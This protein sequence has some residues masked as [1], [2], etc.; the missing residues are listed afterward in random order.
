MLTW[1]VFFYR[2]PLPPPPLLPPPLLP[3]L[4]T[5]WPCPKFR[6][7]CFEIW[8]GP[9]FTRLFFEISAVRR[10]KERGQ[11]CK[12]HT[13]AERRYVGG[14]SIWIHGSATRNETRKFLESMPLSFLRAGPPKSRKKA[15]ESW[16]HP[17]LET[18]FAKLTPG[19]T[20]SVPQS[21]PTAH[22]TAERT[23]AVYPPLKRPQPWQF[24]QKW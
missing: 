3:V 7:I 11:L 21:R 13:G 15:G 10:E 23:Y 4:L 24:F 1:N 9:A 14:Y 12:R 17:N 2:A 16:T 5:T 20:L 19:P 6:E 18:N 8:V 22:A